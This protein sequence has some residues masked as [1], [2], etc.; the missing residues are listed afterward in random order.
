MS[1]PTHERVL[2]LAP[3][4]RDA[5]VALQLLL[6]QQRQAMV[7]NSV[8]QLVEELRQDAGSALV[9]EEALH[10][11]NLRPLCNWLA[12][13]PPWSDF[14]F[15]LLSGKRSLRRPEVADVIIGV[16]GNVIVL[17]RPIS[18]Q[19][20]TSAIDSTLRARRRQYQTRNHL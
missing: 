12:E 20:L 16:L 8:Q 6:C 7:C 4:G 19:T 18:V 1:D 15:V 14:P 13:Q 17:E 10:G 5:A 11:A 9:A 3:R 2:V